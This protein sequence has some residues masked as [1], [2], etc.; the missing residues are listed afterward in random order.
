MDILTYEDIGEG[1]GVSHFFYQPQG[2]NKKYKFIVR[3]EE[4][5][6]VKTKQL[7]LF[8][9]GRHTYRVLVTN[10]EG[11][12]EEIWRFYDDHANCENGIK[13]LIGNFHLDKMP[14]TSWF[15]NAAY[16][17]AVILAYNLFIWFKKFCLPRGIGNIT[18]ETL[19]LKYIVIAAKLIRGARK[20][21]LQISMHFRYK[22][23]FQRTLKAIESFS[24][25]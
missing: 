8:K 21:K 25:G 3:R 22:E 16:F 2:W 1:Y 15:A 20:L 5:K 11:K 23:E 13:E 18:M 4:I 9:I 19:R 17:H 14:S 10:I 6:E 7:T 12:D 24:F